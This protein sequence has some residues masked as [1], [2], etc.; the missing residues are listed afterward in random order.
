[1][2]FTAPSSTHRRHWSQEVLPF[3]SIRGQLS[4]YTTEAFGALEPY[5]GCWRASRVILPYQLLTRPFDDIS[6]YLSAH[7]IYTL[8]TDGANRFHTSRPLRRLRRPHKMPS[9]ISSLI[10]WTSVTKSG[11]TRTTKRLMA[12][13]HRPKVPSPPRQGLPNVVQRQKAR[14]L[15]SRSLSSSR[16]MS[17]SL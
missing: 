2:R 17:L 15:T 9:R 13:E 12:K 5:S 8:P 4:S 14:N 6:A 7:N 10:S 3:I 16:R 1:M 11:S